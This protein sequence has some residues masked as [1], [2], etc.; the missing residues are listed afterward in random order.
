MAHTMPFLLPKIPLFLVI[1]SGRQ[2]M[3]EKRLHSNIL[4]I[5]AFKPMS[6][7]DGQ[8]SYMKLNRV[9]LTAAS[10]LFLFAGLG[11]A[12]H[13]APPPP[14]PP[15]IA[16]APPLIQLAEHNGFETGRSDGA[17]AA[18]SGAPYAARRT[19]AF[20]DCPG[21]DPHLGPFEA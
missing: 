17:R 7:L 4:F 5:D 21:Y 12:H 3:T 8:E 16:Q 9:V 13:Y 19:R 2:K 15:P 18:E 11:C 20:H 10:S 14:P 6:R 1:L